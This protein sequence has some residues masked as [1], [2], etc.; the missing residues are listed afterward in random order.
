MVTSSVTDTG[1]GLVAAAPARPVQSVPDP[2]LRRGLRGHH[3]KESADLVGGVGGRSGVIEA[4]EATEVPLSAPAARRAG[5]W[6]GIGRLAAPLPV[7]FLLALLECEQARPWRPAIF[8]IG[9]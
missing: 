7:A 3:F 1:E 4:G 6:P 8:G 2:L 9:A 5:E